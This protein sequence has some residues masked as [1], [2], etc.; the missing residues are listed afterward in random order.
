MT[1][2]QKLIRRLTQDLKDIIGA[3]DNGDPYTS[4][5][6]RFTFL[7]AYNLGHA[8]LEENGMEEIA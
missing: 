7:P 8:Y 1:Q 5:E 4:E 6:L 2:E 3:A